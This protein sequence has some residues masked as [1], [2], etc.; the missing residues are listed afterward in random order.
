MQTTIEAGVLSLAGKFF[1]TRKLQAACF[2]SFGRML[3]CLI[4]LKSPYALFHLCEIVIFP[5]LSDISKKMNTF[6]MF[7]ATEA[8]YTHLVPTEHLAR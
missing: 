4:A 5:A 8:H 3:S 1:A 7:Q 6:G 2:V